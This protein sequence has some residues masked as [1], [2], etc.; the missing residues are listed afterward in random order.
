MENKVFIQSLATYNLIR[1]V[2][3][4]F[5]WYDHIIDY[6]EINFWSFGMPETG[7]DQYLDAVIYIL[8]RSKIKDEQMDALVQAFKNK[9]HRTFDEST[10]H[11][12][13]KMSMFETWWKSIPELEYLKAFKET[14][15]EQKNEF[16]KV[17]IIAFGKAN[18]FW[19]PLDADRSIQTEF[20]AQLVGL[21]QLL[22]SQINLRELYKNHQLNNIKDIEKELILAHNEKQ[23]KISKESELTSTTLVYEKLWKKWLE[24]ERK[25]LSDIERLIT[26]DN[27]PLPEK[28]TQIIEG[29]SEYGFSEYLITNSFKPEDI[30]QLLSKHSGR[31]QFP[32]C[33]ALFYEIGYI[34]YFINELHN[35]HKKN[36]F[37]A[38]AGIFDGDDRRVRGNVNMLI[39]KDCKENPIEFT[40][41]NYIQ[42]VQKELEGLK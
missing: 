13:L 11:L 4:R 22:T 15:D 8:E 38:M 28:T 3:D 6:S 26:N 29:L 25:F 39:N 34:K 42:I 20:Q 1:C 41:Q 36:S 21:T 10:R 30:Y 33:I 31:E 24:E 17:G 37:I 9:R 23:S 35:G 2:I 27:K 5:G 40:S 32:Y 14:Y 16:R 18:R 19:H 7:Y 12:E